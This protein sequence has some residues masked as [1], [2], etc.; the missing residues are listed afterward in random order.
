MP[1]R[2][3][4]LNRAL[5]SDLDATALQGEDGAEIFAGNRLPE[6][7]S[8]VAIAYAGHQ[9]GHFVPQL[10]DGKASAAMCRSRGPV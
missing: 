10:G 7:E 3:I 4:R 8:P 2:L 5:A 9:F 6:G 1:V